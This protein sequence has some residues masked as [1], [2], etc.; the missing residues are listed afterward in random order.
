MT[1]RVL[2]TAHVRA[3][4]VIC[5]GNSYSYPVDVYAAGCIIWTILTGGGIMI[6]ELRSKHLRTKRNQQKFHIGLLRY[7]L[8]TSVRNTKNM[9]IKRRNSMLYHELRTWPARER[10]LYWEF[11]KRINSAQ[12]AGLI[13]QL[14]RSS[15]K[16]ACALVS[17]LIW[18]F[19]TERV[20]ISAKSLWKERIR[21]FQKT[22]LASQGGDNSKKGKFLFKEF[23]GFSD[24]SETTLEKKH[25]TGTVGK[26]RKRG[27]NRAAQIFVNKRI[28][29]D[30]KKHNN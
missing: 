13:K 24:I 25:N 20:E 5:E 26:K 18:R 6:P 9:T 30:Q 29:E 3:P 14:D 17:K 19:D 22:T 16:S 28:K 4:E 15:K 11:Y 10:T 21:F 7:L 23:Y 27:G 1:G 12:K 8:G 2:T